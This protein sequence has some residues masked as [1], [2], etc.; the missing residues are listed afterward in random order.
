MERK[1][2]LQ[3]KLEFLRTL[4]Q[5]NW[6]AK[7]SFPKRTSYNGLSFWIW[8]RK[9]TES[10]FLP[11]KLNKVKLLV[12]RRVRAVFISKNLLELILRRITD[13]ENRI[14]RLEMLEYEKAQNTISSLSSKTTDCK[15]SAL[16]IEEIINKCSDVWDIILNYIIQTFKLSVNIQRIVRWSQLFCIWRIFGLDCKSIFT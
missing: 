3:R 16:A 5:K 12:E 15:K 1:G 14:K 4:C 13:F 2:T 6:R 9:N 11:K 10:I 7:Q 8:I